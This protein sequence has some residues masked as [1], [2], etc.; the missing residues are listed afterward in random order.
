MSRVRHGFRKAGLPKETHTKSR[1]PKQKTFHTKNP[2]R[3][4]KEKTTA[5][6]TIAKLL[7]G[8]TKKHGNHVQYQRK[9]VENVQVSDLPLPD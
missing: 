6:Q 1:E 9:S 4:G 5:R 2:K 3:A 7:Y 8:E